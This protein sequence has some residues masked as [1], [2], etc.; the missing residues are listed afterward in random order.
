M[1]L[2]K[3]Y[4][5][6]KLDS[7]IYTPLFS[8]LVTI[9]MGG[10][11]TS[12]RP[13]A[14][15]DRSSGIPAGYLRD[16]DF[17]FDPPDDMDIPTVDRR[18]SDGPWGWRLNRHEIENYLLD[19]QVVAAKF[20]V[21]TRTW[22]GHLCDAARRI[23]WYQVARWT[24]GFARSRLP[25]HY[26]LQTSP[27]NVKEMRLPADLT[28]KT[29]LDWGRKVIA[30]F[31]AKVDESLGE[32]S[33]NDQIEVRRLKFSDELLNDHAQVLTWCSGKDLFAALPT[34]GIKATG[35]DSPRTLCK[36][37]RDWVRDHP[38]LFV[39]FFPEFAALKLEMSGSASTA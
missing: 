2:N 21:E 4:V 30:E 17:D 1:R 34:A 19:P 8:G 23:R 13:Q 33:V 9:E 39:G 31:L 10:S 37:L 38:D 12:I 7:E 20:D 6:G 5:E 16:R 22:Q 36:I 11:K 14:D 24:I 18:D 28:E 32:S 29:S 26:K 3:L 25:L 15:N 27:D 35:V